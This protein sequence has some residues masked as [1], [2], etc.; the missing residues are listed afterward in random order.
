ML[1]MNSTNRSKYTT[2]SNSANSRQLYFRKTKIGI[3]ITAL[4]FMFVYTNTPAQS[5]LS[6]LK[7]AHYQGDESGN[8]IVY[9]PVPR[10]N[11]YSL[12]I[13]F[14]P[15]PH[16]MGSQKG[17]DEICL[18]ALSKELSEAVSDTIV[19]G[20]NCSA[21]RN[22]IEIRYDSLTSNMIFFKEVTR[23]FN[24]PEFSDRYIQAGKT[25]IIKNNFPPSLPPYEL[26]KH[27]NAALF[28]GRNH[29]LGELYT[30]KGIK[31]I[32]ADNCTAYYR[33]HLLN[34]QKFIHLYAPPEDST[35]AHFLSQLPEPITGT[36]TENFPVPSNPAHSIVRF[37]ESPQE[38][39]D[40]STY[41]NLIYK[42]PGFKINSKNY[43]LYK[44]SHYIL[45]AHPNGLLQYC[46]H[47]TA[48]TADFSFSETKDTP[49]GS[50]HNMGLILQA[51]N[52][53]NSLKTF[54]LLMN[55][56]SD[57]TLSDKQFNSYRSAYIE[58][59]HQKYNEAEDLSALYNE[60][61]LYQLPND[62]FANYEKKIL[63]VTAREIRYFADKFFL[64]DRYTVCLYG[65][66]EINDEQLLL[67]APFAEIW[68]YDRSD[69]PINHI[70][71][72]FS[73]TDVIRN[74]L[75]KT[76][77]LEEPESHYIEIKTDYYFPTDTL[78]VQDKIYRKNS[79]FL[80]YRYNLSDTISNKAFSVVLYD[81]KKPYGLK[82]EQYI[83]LRGKD[84]LEVEKQKLIYPEK[85]WLNNEF[86]KEI[87][88][89]KKEAGKKYILVHISKQDIPIALN[90]YSVKDSLKYRSE[91]FQ[92]DSNVNILSIPTYRQEGAKNPRLIP[93]QQILECDN[94][95]IV[96]IADSV[97]FNIKLKNKIFKAK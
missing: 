88:G 13:F 75:I 82:N 72:Q 81:G 74:F 80:K 96:S 18:Y 63:Q 58:R 16:L 70:P 45:A 8:H 55:Y 23:V 67:S 93:S 90:Y 30:K 86:Q 43:A 60:Q 29:P 35:A 83:A 95:K 71:Y 25:Q 52:L 78:H 51:S 27:K 21:G 59:F 32:Q 87:M 97:N 38:L 85:S 84:S 69:N 5:S 3:I 77:T 24:N 9:T 37:F 79:K 57:S 66:P 39:I 1:N 94:I 4:V 47:D 26:L 48:S 15:A 42:L 41:L 56:L 61:F 31:D 36:K 11:H 28:Y 40:S 50:A 68:Q 64:A 89:Y 46:M 2:V 10:I 92:N 22:H 49:T 62:Y 76:N 33:N 17:I 91:Q 65:K 14:N 19:F 54:K 20:L 73:G 7:S 6:L 53:N 34:A 44:L 12:F